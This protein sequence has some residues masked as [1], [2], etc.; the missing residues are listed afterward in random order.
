MYE[1]YSVF[2]FSAIFTSMMAH[3]G[4]GKERP[5]TTCPLSSFQFSSPLPNYVKYTSISS[6]LTSTFDLK[7]HKSYHKEPLQSKKLNQPG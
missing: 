1:I 2:I 4:K 3:K 5:K 7:D 6:M